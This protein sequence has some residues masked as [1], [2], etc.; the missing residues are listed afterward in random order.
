MAE[1]SDLQLEAGSGA[2]SPHRL[3]LLESHTGWRTPQNQATTSTIGERDP[4]RTYGT[5]RRDALDFQGS[6]LPNYAILDEA[7]SDSRISSSESAKAA[8][9]LRAD[10]RLAL[11]GTPIEN[12]L[13]RAVEVCSSS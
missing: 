2:P 7:Q 12:H 11:S 3:R 13:R 6:P 1:I 10:H 9:L 5:L 4:G 8:R